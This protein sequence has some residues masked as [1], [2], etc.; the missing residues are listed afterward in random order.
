MSSEERYTG[1]AENLDEATVDYIS[2]LLNEEMIRRSQRRDSTKARVVLARAGLERI[3][4]LWRIL[5]GHAW[6]SMRVA[7]DEEL[8]QR[9]RTGLFAQLE[10]NEAHNRARELAHESP[11]EDLPSSIERDD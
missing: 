10:G 11:L 1:Q 6:M 2:S 4:R 8:Y 5:F 7:H 9:L 3:R